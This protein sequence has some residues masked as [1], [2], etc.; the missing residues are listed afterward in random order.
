[1]TDTAVIQ[2]LTELRYQGFWKPCACHYAIASLDG[3]PAVV[4]VQGGGR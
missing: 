4:F 1:M 3:K 2:P